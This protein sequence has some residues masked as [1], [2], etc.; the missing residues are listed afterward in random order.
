M[1][2]DH[3]GGAKAEKVARVNASLC[4]TWSR[5][6]GKCGGKDGSVEVRAMRKRAMEAVDQAPGGS[7]E[8]HAGGKE[9]GG[10]RQRSVRVSSNDGLR[11]RH[12]CSGA[13]QARAGRAKPPRWVV[14]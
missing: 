12:A 14:G 11:A 13:E 4:L 5:L 9:N 7:A 6:E 10:I 2:S 3:S 1:I 8:G